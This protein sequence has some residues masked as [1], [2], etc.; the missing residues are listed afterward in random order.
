MAEDATP[1]Y[2]EGVWAQTSNSMAQPKVMD[3]PKEVLDRETV[4]AKPHACQY[5]PSGLPSPTCLQQSHTTS[6]PCSSSACLSSQMSAA[7]F[8]NAA[9]EAHSRR[10]MGG[11]LSAESHALP[12]PRQ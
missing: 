8:A 7:W 1:E 2:R 12:L 5:F 6:L 4:K 9:L 10:R 11:P 3:I